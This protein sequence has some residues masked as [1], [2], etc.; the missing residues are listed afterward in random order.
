[1][2]IS[3]LSSKN[4]RALEF[5]RL[6]KRCCSN[7]GWRTS[8][9]GYIERYPFVKIVVNPDK[10]PT[11]LITSGI[12]GNEPCAPLGIID[13]LMN[14]TV[15]TDLRIIIIPMIN[16]TGFDLDQRKND[17]GKDLNRQFNNGKP[18]TEELVLLKAAL[19]H[20]QIDL[21]L[22]LHEDQ[23]H[24]G[25]YLYYADVEEDSCRSMLKTLSSKIKV[26]ESDKIYGDINDDG[27]IY[28]SL[29]NKDPKHA[30]SLENAI[31]SLGIAQLTFETPTDAEAK[32][33][34][35]T[36]RK[37]IEFV[38]DHFNELL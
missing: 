19:K 37:A 25:I 28:I 2:K 11:L 9:V 15:P 13:W 32:E 12:H 22:S 1:M 38:I 8:T 34:V 5:F 20:E 29:K 27:L 26:C 10:E 3:D 33:R 18:P 7:R 4:D 35:T 6:L 36:H 31:Q 16:P 23:G 14:G 17:D 24:D 21:L 30:Y